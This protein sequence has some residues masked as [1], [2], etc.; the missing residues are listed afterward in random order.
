MQKAGKYSENPYWDGTIGSDGCG[1]TST[2]IILTGYGFKV[3]PETILNDKYPNGKNV[4]PDGNDMQ[5][6]M[7]EFENYGIESHL[8]YNTGNEFKET[9]LNNLKEGRP[10]LIHVKNKI[11]VGNRGYKGHYMTLL[12]MNNNGEIL[13]GD[14]N[15]NENC[16]YFKQDEIFT[17][18]ISAAIVIDSNEAKII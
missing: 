16:G 3:N 10:V 4:C 1:I 2:A 13:L 11:K 15:D 9:V 17:D 7:N 18:G 6:Y 14:P 8:T 5:Y 12:G